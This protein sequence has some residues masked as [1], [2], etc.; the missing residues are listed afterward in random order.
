MT[1][2]GTRW[3]FGLTWRSAPLRNAGCWWKSWRNT[4]A[5]SCVRESPPRVCGKRRAIRRRRGSSPSWLCSSPSGCRA[6]RPGGRPQARPENEGLQGQQRSQGQ[7]RPRQV[8]GSVFLVPAVPEVSAVPAFPARR[9]QEPVSWSPMRIALLA[10]VH[11]NLAALEAVVDDLGRRG[12]DTVVNLGDGLSGPLL[13]RETAR[14]L[15]SRDWLHLAG[16]HER[17]LL[18]LAPEERG[19]SDAY[20]Y[21]QLSPAE[22][23]WI[24]TL[25]PSG[26][27]GDEV[28]LC[29]GTPQSDAEYFLETVTPGGLR[30][31]TGE[32]I[33]GRLHGAGAI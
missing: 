2:R 21:S 33:E 32:E 23:A 16:N 20:A 5:G 22:L 15:M 9:R 12:V 18:T 19:A 25:R 31:A 28:L 14:F 29:H 7:Q 26:T 10:D 27:L 30:A 24:A 4:G 6:T 13:P 1:S 17:Q 8:S 3:S 11:G